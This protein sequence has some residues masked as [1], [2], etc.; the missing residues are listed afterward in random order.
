MSQEATI[1]TIPAEFAG[2]PL[3]TPEL[4]RHAHAHGIQIHVWT[5]N[6]ID[7]MNELLDL[8]VDG[9]VTDYPGR[10]V[11]C[12]EERRGRGEG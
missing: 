1:R 10:L 12:L 5:I 3:V 7:E 2:R 9:L 6:E 4:V 11:T 8:G